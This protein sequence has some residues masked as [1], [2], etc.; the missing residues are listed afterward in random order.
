MGSK[1]TYKKD[2]TKAKL[3]EKPVVPGRVQAWS[4]V[5]MI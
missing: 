2:E 1:Y 4:G 5:K 3:R